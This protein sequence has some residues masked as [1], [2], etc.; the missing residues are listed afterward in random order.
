MVLIE[1]NTVVYMYIR[2]TRHV[3]LSP[4][5]LLARNFCA[6]AAVDEITIRKRLFLRWRVQFISVLK[7]G[8]VS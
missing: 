4:A 5:E 3:I 6:G 8:Q 7:G 1:P 2:S